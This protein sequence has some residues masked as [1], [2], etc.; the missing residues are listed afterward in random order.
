MERYREFAQIRMA[1][2]ADEA[3]SQCRRDVVDAGRRAH[4]SEHW[5]PVACECECC[6]TD[7]DV[8]HHGPRGLQPVAL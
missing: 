1:A 7:C 3:N 2:W 6:G 8:A 4:R 5:N